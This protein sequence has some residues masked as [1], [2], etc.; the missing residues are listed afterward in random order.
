MT[1]L[2]SVGKGSQIESS[3]KRKAGS[4][5]RG[6][7]SNNGGISEVTKSAAS[8]RNTRRVWEKASSSISDGQA[9]G[10]ER[11]GTEIRKKQ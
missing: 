11:P 8:A 1:L 3:K 2:G 9:I 6:K 4:D 10:T 5:K 7:L